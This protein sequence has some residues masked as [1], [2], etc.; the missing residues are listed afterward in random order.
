MHAFEFRTTA[1]NGIIRIPD[2]YAK[3]ITSEVRVILYTEEK[4]EVT[5]SPARSSLL[6]LAGVF[7][8]C[9]DMDVK[10]IRA[11]RREKYENPD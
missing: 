7:K 2:E 1:S 5:M 6:D 4:P 10:E 3:K 11:E 8:G 9:E